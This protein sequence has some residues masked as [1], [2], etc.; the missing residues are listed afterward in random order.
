MRA[1]K[2]TIALIVTKDN[3]RLKGRLIL[4]FQPVLLLGH[5]QRS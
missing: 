4:S 3:T 5:S 1:M 2:Y